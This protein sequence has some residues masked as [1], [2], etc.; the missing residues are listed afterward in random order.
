MRLLL[1][2]APLLALGCGWA[3]SRSLV[4][5]DTYE[6]RCGVASVCYAAAADECPDGYDELERQQWSAGQTV[7]SQTYGPPENQTTNVQVYDRPA[8]RLV[9]RCSPSEQGRARE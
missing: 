6:I 8:N 1:P 3:A 4:G 5:P 2:F 7:Q 9:V